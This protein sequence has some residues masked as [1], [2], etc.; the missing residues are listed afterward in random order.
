MYDGLTSEISEVSQLLRQFWEETKFTLRFFFIS[1]FFREREWVGE[2]VPHHVFVYV[3]EIFL[4]KGNCQVNL[5]NSFSCYILLTSRGVKN[6]YAFQSW[7]YIILY[8]YYIYNTLIK[9]KI[10]MQTT[11]CRNKNNTLIKPYESFTKFC[12]APHKT[13]E[14]NFQ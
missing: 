7:Y 12:K 13:Q 4:S 8:L 10:K 5:E 14:L 6:A 9:I 1:F 2:A 11:L 3:N